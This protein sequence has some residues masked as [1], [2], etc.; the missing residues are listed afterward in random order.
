MDELLNS[1]PAGGRVAVVTMTGSCCPVTRAHVQCFVEARRIILGE[2]SR[3]SK[4]EHFTEVV[5]FLSLNSDRH[6]SGKLAEKGLAYIPYRQ[7]AQLVELAASELPWL[8]FNP[9]REQ[10]A[11]ETLARQWH[12]LRFVRY[13]MNGADDVLKYQKWNESG[14]KRR[15]IAMGR[16]GQSEQL[17]RQIR[18]SGIDLDMGWYII[19]PELP[20]I[21][22]TAVRQACGRGDREALEAMLHPLVAEWCLTQSPYRPRERR[23]PAVV[24][25]AGGAE[26][27]DVQ[28]PPRVPR[29]APHARGAG[30]AD[31]EEFVKSGAVITGAEFLQ[32]DGD[33]RSGS[34]TPPPEPEWA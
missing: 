27:A 26:A 6:V 19:G 29:H 3:P 4:L 28:E 16:P 23:Q 17:A 34:P 21:S 24:D 10:E 33:V 20:D 8:A 18:R 12:H 32:A 15:G 13:S 9:L 22:S 31:V 5:G 2:A 7:R 25:D 1:I 30:D 11:V 14:P